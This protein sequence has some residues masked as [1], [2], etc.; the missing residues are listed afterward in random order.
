LGKRVLELLAHWVGPLLIRLLGLT[1]RIEK[2]GV[3]NI[4]KARSLSGNLIYALWHGRLLLLTYVHRNEGIDVL[5]STHQDGEYIARLITGLGFG[6]VRGSS[7]RGGTGAVLKLTGAGSE[8]HDIGITPD[9]PHG[10]RERCQ[11]GVIYVAKRNR[12]AVVPIGASQKPSLVLSSWDR[13]MVPLPFARCRVVYGEPAVYDL[14]LS[15]ES[16]D[17]ATRDLEERMK[18]VTEEAESGCGRKTE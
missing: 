14:S 16:I 12:M 6:T 9:G 18:A 5:V 2:S 3:E 7:T 4:A 8:K 11:P 1:L 15:E 17:A 10:P 13:F